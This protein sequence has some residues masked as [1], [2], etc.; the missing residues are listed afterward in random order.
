MQKI[1]EL[2]TNTKSEAEKLKNTNIL[3]E[4]ITIGDD[5]LFKIKKIEDLENIENLQYNLKIILKNKLNSLLFPSFIIKN[6][7]ILQV[8]KEEGF[9]YFLSNCKKKIY[10]YNYKDDK[11]KIE[12][13]ACELNKVFNEHFNI[14]LHLIKCDNS[15]IDILLKRIEEVQQYYI[16]EHGIWSQEFIDNLGDE[17]SKISFRTF[18]EQRAKG[19]ILFSSPS[20]YPIIP[21]I[22]GKEWRINR[23]NNPPKLPLFD[24]LSSFFYN[25]I[26]IFEQYSIENIVEVPKNGFVIDAG[27]FVADTAIYFAQK[28]GENGKVYSF[29]IDPSNLAQAEKHLALNN[30]N[31]VEMINKA[32]SNKNESFKITSN[33]SQTKIDNVHGSHLVESITIDDFVKEKDIKVSYIKSD[34]EGM[35]LALL[36]GAKNTIQRD[37]PICGITAYHKREDYHVLAKLL[38]EYCPEYTFY[39][40]CETEPVIFAIVK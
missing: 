21:P 1:I 40:R 16:D 30:I 7:I 10:L 36:E 32:I 19:N 17:Y 26:Y 11:N 38:K 9:S 4:I 22:E 24:N 12:D 23:R 3:Y 34:I 2:F 31:N 15:A 13:I 5:S 18:L 29:E 20:M 37:K 28:V 6:N 33:K 14:K 8:L 35:E 27:G 25:S 39:F